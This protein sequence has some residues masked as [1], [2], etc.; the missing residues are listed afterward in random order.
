MEYSTQLVADRI[1]ELEYTT[2]S[3]LSPHISVENILLDENGAT[4]DI[5]I[6]WED[7]EEIL[8]ECE[9]PVNFLEGCESKKQAVEDI[10]VRYERIMNRLYIAETNEEGAVL[11]F[12]KKHL[13]KLSTY[14]KWM[15]HPV[16]ETYDNHYTKQLEERIKDA[17]SY[18][19]VLYS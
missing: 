17:E 8:R 4:A 1:L 18:L 19:T 2:Y 15:L 12:I 16:G 5:R 11:D 6:T 10:E 9:Y 14:H 13:H 7:R 3:R